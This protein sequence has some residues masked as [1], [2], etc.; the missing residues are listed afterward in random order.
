MMNTTNRLLVSIF[1]GEIMTLLTGLFSN[2][3]QMMVGAEW[4]GFPLAWLIRMIV[5][6]EYNPWRIEFVNF[7][8]D[9][10]VW[11]VILLVIVFILEKVR[12]PASK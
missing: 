12:K 4:F 1:S 6:P 7:L 2:T 11:S 5:A 10:V 9:V 3:P 8:A